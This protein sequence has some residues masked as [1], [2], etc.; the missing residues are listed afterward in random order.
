MKSGPD[1]TGLENQ[2]VPALDGVQAPSRRARPRRGLIAHR[3][4]W[5]WLVFFLMGTVAIVVY[6]AD[7][8]SR[9]AVPVLLIFLYFLYGLNFRQRSNVKFAD[10]LYFMG[11]LWT[12]VAL[13]DALFSGLTAST[14]FKAFGYALI[15]TAAGM[16]C[17][18]LVLQF[19]ETTSDVLAEANEE[20]DRGV[21]RL[22]EELGRATDV[23][24][25]FRTSLEAQIDDQVRALGRSLD[26][27]RA[28]LVSANAEAAGFIKGRV[29]LSLKALDE[30][31]AQWAQRAVESVSTVS[32]ATDDLAA[33]LKRV[34]VPQDVLTRQVEASTRV[35][36][37][38]ADKFT[39]DL[40][41]VGD[42]LTTGI[43]AFV[44]SLPHIPGKAEVDG[45]LREVAKSV[46]AVN[47]KYKSL[48]QAGGDVRTGLDELAVGLGTLK[49]RL[50]GLVATA[51]SLE[52]STARL[53]QE[54]ITRS[55]RGM[56]SA[57]EATTQ[58]RQAAERLQQVVTE[59]LAFVRSRIES[60]RVV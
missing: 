23:V 32:K 22:A 24:A 6:R 3:L 45:A 10:S 5:A 16:F 12:L 2:S 14:V 40:Q 43:K 47:E 8:P 4:G 18:I 39:A 13:I 42:S 36:K 27:V 59:V 56:E 48:A 25:R 11:F 35:L 51:T 28:T 30:A 19:Q 44:A 1:S 54:T 49:G 21:A 7:Q 58:A 37:Q 53:A 17:R 57:E 29:E 41:A 50:D 46:R 52:A 9:M 34:D 55:E 15:T 33:R 26:S 31:T 38:A 60:D 20:I